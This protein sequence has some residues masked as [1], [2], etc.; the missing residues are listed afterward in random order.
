MDRRRNRFPWS[1]HL[2]L[3]GESCLRSIVGSITGLT[4]DQEHSEDSE[5][6]A[7]TG[8]KVVIAGTGRAGTTLLMAVLSDLG[9]DTGIRP[10]V[11][12]SGK[13]G[14]LERNIEKT[15]A[16][17]VK[18]PGLSTRLGPLLAEGRVSVEHVIIPVRNLDVAVASRVR[19]A[20][21]GMRSSA[22]GG[23]IGARR[24]SRQRE[25]LATMLYELIH[26]VAD[27]DIDHTLLM[28]PR[29]ANDAAYLFEKLGWLAP[30]KT[31]DDFRACLAARYD[32]NRITEAP[33]GKGERLRSAL[34]APVGFIRRAI[35]ESQASRV[36]RS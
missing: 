29:F 3:I 20:K 28:F 26:T 23:F 2:S 15:A 19:V 27:H 1:V 30:G 33:L 7:I 35:P 32:P 21:Y 17:I 9:C 34:L 4:N 24:S 16:R 12:V 6:T 8:A 25:V 11:E 22:P 14:G 31:E 36:K 5:R 10:G 18:A 13:L